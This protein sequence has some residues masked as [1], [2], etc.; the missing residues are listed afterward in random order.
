MADIPVERFVGPAVVID[1]SEKAAQNKDAQVTVED[2]QAWEKKHGQI[3]TGSIVLMNSGWGKFWY[4]E[5]LFRGNDTD[6]ILYIHFPG[7]CYSL[8]V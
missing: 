3:P 7:Q 8:F 1:I 5:S 4:N 2:L 6:D